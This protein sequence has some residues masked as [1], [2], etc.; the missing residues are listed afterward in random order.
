MTISAKIILDSVSPVGDRLT[1]A[2]L[3]YPRF[4]H[5]EFM[6]HRVF[7]RNAASSRAIPVSTMLDMVK[8]NP[9]VP[10][11]FG[12]NGKGMQDHGQ[13]SPFGEKYAYTLWLEA[14]DA[15]VVVARKMLEAKEPPHKQIINRILEPYVHMTTIVTSTNWENFFALRNDADADPTFR[16][17]ADTL[18]IAYRASTPAVREPG[19]WHLP[20]VD[21]VDITEALK[22]AVNDAPPGV[23]DLQQ[24]DD[25]VTALCLAMSTARCARVSYLNHEGKRSGILEDMAMVDRLMTARKCHASPAE[26][27]A[28]PDMCDGGVYQRPTLHGNFTGWVQHRKLWPS[29]A[30]RQT[31]YTGPVSHG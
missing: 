29:E 18:E 5:S 31:K 20:F 3:V 9:A 11:R 12:L 2:V 15:A 24:L 7:S 28:S 22:H 26:H 6:T 1:T 27:Q 30:V 14:R 19:E 13:L 25:R 16:A 8:Y 4:I 21:E 23:V 10:S 17:L